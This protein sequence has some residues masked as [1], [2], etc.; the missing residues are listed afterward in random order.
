MCASVTHRGASASVGTVRESNTL[1][2]PV[3]GP[4]VVGTK[5]SQLL[6]GRTIV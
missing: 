3:S 6:C 5:Q 2:I 1:G 4:G